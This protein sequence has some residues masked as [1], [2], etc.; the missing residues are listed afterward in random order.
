MVRR[1]AVH[2]MITSKKAPK[3]IG[4]YS[5]AVRVKRP[6]SML[7][8]SGQTPIELPAGTVFLGDIK[9]QAELSLAHVRNIVLD[10]G[11]TVDEIVKTTIYLT[12]LKNFDVVNDVYAKMFVGQTLPARATVQG[13]ALPKGVGIEVDCI[14]VKQEAAVEDLLDDSAIA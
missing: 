13:A 7:F 3:P 9:K 10:A 2:D 1:S 4:P 12:D 11:F 6:G 5:H 8:V 14:A